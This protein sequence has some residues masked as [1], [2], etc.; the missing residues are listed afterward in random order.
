[1]ADAAPTPVAA[2][3]VPIAVPSAGGESKPAAPPV[4]TPV[5]RKHRLKVNGA[6]RELPETEV[7][8][9]ARQR[10]AEGERWTEAH[11]MRTEAEAFRTKLGPD[12]GRKAF[13][14]LQEMGWT[15][16]QIRTAQEDYLVEEV[17]AKEFGPDGQPLSAEAKEL[18]A[19]RAKEAQ[20]AEEDKARAESAK[21]E[22]QNAAQKQYTES[23]AAS[24][25]QALEKLGLT[26]PAAA[27]AA[28]RMAGLEEGNLRGAAS[29]HPLKTPDELAAL[30]GKIF[31]TEFQARVGA[32]DGDAL[33]D[34]LG[35]PLARKVVM[36]VLAR[37]KRGGAP[38]G[39]AH[40]VGEPINGRPRD[41]STGRYTG[42][43]TSRDTIRFVRDSY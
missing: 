33:L 12:Q 5:E 11:R 10:L 28:K 39:A 30:E 1:M 26:G 35:E 15:P 21:T 7:L 41:A 16:D 9:L 2:P 29:G 43:T 31:A 6:E 14:A 20:R 27:M 23:Y 42:E 37:G 36:A 4:E 22:R 25:G 40:G 13:A 8:S 19:L 17:Y 3:V 18:A 34:S 24:F 38:A 32:L